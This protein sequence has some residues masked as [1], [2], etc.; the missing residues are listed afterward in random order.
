MSYHQAYSTG[1]LGQASLFPT[2]S[3]TCRL[4]WPLRVTNPW[5]SPPLL[6][7]S[8]PSSR[9][10]HRIWPGGS[11]PREQPLL[12]PSA[13]M[14]THRTPQT[15]A[16]A[17]LGAQLLTC[18]PEIPRVHKSQFGFKKHIIDILCLCNI[19][20]YVS[21]FN[22][23]LHENAEKTGFW[24]VCT[25]TL[26][27]RSQKYFQRNILPITYTRWHLRGLRES[28]I[29]LCA[30]QGDVSTSQIWKCLAGALPAKITYGKN[31]RL[32]AGEQ[33][34]TSSAPNCLWKAESNRCLGIHSCHWISYPG[35]FSGTLL[36]HS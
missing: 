18:K 27:D 10:T 16:T 8:A 12:N 29:T 22:R 35:R 33:E 9:G 26:E 31:Q 11:S 24:K 3:Q 32:Q 34:L 17:Q 14:C 1:K 15:S 25:Q 13:A 4:T 19:Y 30:S 28:L 5:G 7:T 23:S 20:I 2:A 36:L 21:K 6:R